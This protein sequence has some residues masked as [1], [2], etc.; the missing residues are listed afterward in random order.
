MAYETGSASNHADLFDKLRTFLKSVPVG[1]TELY[2]SG[3]TP[4]RMFFRAPGLSGT[5]YIH[6]GF[7]LYESIGTDT[8]GFY[9]FMSQSYDAGLSIIAQ[10]GMSGT[11]FHPTWDQT[12]PYWFFANGQRA[13]IV[14]KISTVY[15]AS[16]IGRFLPYGTAGE[17]GLPYYLAMPW[18]AATRF[19][20]INEG[21]R[22]FWDPGYG[23]IMLQPSGNWYGMLNFYEQSSAEA[24]ATGQNYIYPYAAGSSDTHARFRELRENVDGSYPA[25]PLVIMGANPASDIY[26]ELDGAFAT[27]GFSLASEDTLTIGADTY[28]VFQNIFRTTRYNYCAIKQA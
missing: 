8:F 14:T 13:I 20:S 18:N 27:S 22:N 11:K 26:G 7:E 19:S 28:R 10:P 16:Y 25:M 17:Y 2:Y 5:E 15:T 23:G 9:G 21:V 6:C 24:Y 4:A 1:W 12:I 3:V